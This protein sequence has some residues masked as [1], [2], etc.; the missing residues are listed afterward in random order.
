MIHNTADGIINLFPENQ[1]NTVFL[2]FTVDIVSLIETCNRRQR[3]LGQ[4]KNHSNGI[5]LR[6][7]TQQISPL[8][9]THT[10]HITGAVQYGNNLLQI[11]VGNLLTSCNI[12]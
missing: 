2:L 9:S 1:G 4:T 8:C 10:A 12:F 3:S 11:F 6:C 7:F 5:I